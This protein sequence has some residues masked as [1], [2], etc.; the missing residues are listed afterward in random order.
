MELK[1]IREF[2]SL[3]ETG[4]YFE[5]AERLFITTSS[6]SR[7]IKALEEELGMPLFDRTTRKVAL[8][9]HGRLFLPYAKQF[10]KID[11]ECTMAF[12][13]EVMYSKGAIGIGSI[14]MMKA[15]QISEI[16]RQY[17]QNNRNVVINV[18]EADSKPLAEMLR[19]SEIDFAFLRNRHISVDEFETIPI[20]Q[21]HLVAVLPKVH[22]LAREAKIHVEQLEGESLLLISRNSFMYQL[23]TDLCRNAGFQPKVV[24]TSQRAENLVELIEQGT[25]IGLLMAKP[26]AP[27]LPDDLT[28]VDIE[29]RV[30]TTVFLAYLKDRKFNTACKRFLELVR[31]IPF[32]E[33]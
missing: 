11:D 16:L 8:N 27:I 6:L 23:C 20:S 19:K 15:Y 26:V 28:L 4:N 14:P 1:Y 21:D 9:R 32:E 22:P 33:A 29:P 30:T 3:A 31:T 17:R 24:F 12:D 5:T 7:H 13:E 10:V 25:G 18:H 2:V